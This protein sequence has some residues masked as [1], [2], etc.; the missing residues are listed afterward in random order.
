MPAGARKSKKTTPAINSNF[1]KK[2]EGS[3]SSSQAKY[4][5]AR[6]ISPYDL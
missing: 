1:Y 5:K 2:R 4:G 3:F 6:S